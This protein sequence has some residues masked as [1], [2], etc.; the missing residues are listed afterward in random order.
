MSRFDTTASK[1][2]PI[3]MP[4]GPSLP[5]HLAHLAN[6]STTPEA[7]AGPSA[8]RP[9]ATEV[10]DEEEDD[11]GPALPPHLAATR[12]SAPSPKRSSQSISAR[13]YDEESDDDVIGPRPDAVGG[14]ASGGERSAVQEFMEREERWAKEREEAKKPKKM[15]R[16]EWMLVPPKSGPLAS[17][18][19]AF[20]N[21]EVY[22]DA[23]QSLRSTIH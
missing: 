15:E 4:I 10:S 20:A 18:T 6:R 21:H 8:C 2:K 12:H 23:V 14:V 7:E 5:P 22:A 19:L 16:E 3:I 1:R 9:P 13:H 11:Y 17:G